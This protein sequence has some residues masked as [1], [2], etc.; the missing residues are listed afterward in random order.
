M[1]GPEDE[2]TVKDLMLN[3]QSWDQEKIMDIVCAKIATSSRGIGSIITQGIEAHGGFPDYSTIMRWIDKDE[4]LCKRYARAKEAQADFMADEMLDICD[5]ARNDYMERLSKGGT[6]SER[7]PD[8][9]LIQRSK[10][11]ID[12]RKWL[13]SK[14]KPKKYG[15]KV[16]TEL[17][18]PDGGPVEVKGIE[19]SFVKAKEVED[20]KGD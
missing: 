2:I 13:A 19:V 20:G 6:E 8:K 10:L 9:E 7:V 16:Q 5:D 12:T 18:G 1:A 3:D 11:R 4:E 17:T 15:D 14:L